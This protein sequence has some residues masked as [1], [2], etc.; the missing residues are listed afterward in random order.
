MTQKVA[1]VLTSH[2]EEYTRRFLE[3]W[4]DE[5]LKEQAVVY[6]NEDHPEKTFQLPKTKVPVKHFSYQD[7]TK[8]LGKDAWIISHKT[9]SG[10]SFGFLKAFQDGADIIISLDHDCYP[11]QK[12]SLRKHVKAL[13]EKVT[14]GWLPSVNVP[15]RGYPYRIRNQSQVV[16]NHG[17]WSNIPDFDGPQ[18]LQFPDVR[19]PAVKY[20]S[21]V[22]PLHNYFPL[23]GMNFAF[24]RDITVLNYFLL[25]GPDWPFDRFDDIWAGI[26]IKKITDHFKVAIKSGAPSI[27][28][29]KGTDPFVAVKK[30]AN[31]LE[32]NEWLWQVVDD[33][34]LTATTYKSAY[35]ELAEK[36]ILD[37]RVKSS[38][39]YEYFQ[40]LSQAMIIWAK[41]FP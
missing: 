19:F 28:H 24:T 23:C 1:V 39:W 5:L 4:N 37:Q 8:D 26:F 10:K 33:M 41:Y 6:L 30:E 36:L 34:T 40:K 9:S 27:H 14:L 12:N 22:I 32:V 11:D 29:D 16:L 3:E 7:H 18:M 20:D 13:S 17:V 15:T 35:I 2:L 31:G 25:M 21:T 38:P